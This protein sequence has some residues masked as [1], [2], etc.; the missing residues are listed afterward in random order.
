MIGTKT[1]KVI[2]VGIKAKTCRIC[3]NSDANKRPPPPHDC[4]KNWSGSAKS[5]ESAIIIDIIK[6][7]EMD[8]KKIGKMIGDD[9]TTTIARAKADPDIKS[10]IEK[11]SDKNHVRKNIANSLYLLQKNHKSLSNKVIQSVQKNI[12]YAIDQNKNNPSGLKQA[13]QACYEHPYGN[14][15]MCN[16]EWCGFLKDSGSYMHSNLPYGK[17]LYR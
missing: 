7:I 8:G 3:S 17:D 15:K 6:E 16:I 10:N 2:G 1:G 4:H 14:H 9:D 5:M 11:I 13:L 12:N